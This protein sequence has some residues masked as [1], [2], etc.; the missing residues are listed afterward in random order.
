MQPAG[1]DPGMKAGKTVIMR[2]SDTP[3]KQAGTES[4]TI[5]NHKKKII[6]PPFDQF[7]KFI[8]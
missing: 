8:L 1:I 6:R 5:D 3:G 7:S 4:I 2:T